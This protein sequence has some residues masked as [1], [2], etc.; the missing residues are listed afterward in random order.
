MKTTTNSKPTTPSTSEESNLTQ[1]MAEVGEVIRNSFDALNSYFD[2]PYVG[3][4][5]VLTALYLAGIK[6]TGVGPEFISKVLGTGYLNLPAVK[7]GGDTKFHFPSIIE[8]EDD[9]ERYTLS[10]L[11]EICLAEL[12]K[13]DNS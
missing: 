8:T 1:S 13:Q 6:P 11:I 9:L 7:I 3:P 4:T 2:S 10:E 5:Q 12:D